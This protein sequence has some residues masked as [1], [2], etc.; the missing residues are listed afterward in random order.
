MCGGVGDLAFLLSHAGGQRWM[1][2]GATGCR[3]G[4]TRTVLTTSCCVPGRSRAAPSQRLTLNS[5]ACVSLRA[6]DVIN[7]LYACHVESASSANS[8]SLLHERRFDHDTWHKGSE[9]IVGM[10]S[11]GSPFV[12]FSYSSSVYK[13]PVQNILSHCMRMYVRCMGLQRM[14]GRPSS[15][16]SFIEILRQPDAIP[17]VDC[18]T[19]ARQP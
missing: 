3:R 6:C 10:C 13:Q 11:F 8:S 9:A 16:C 1:P 5:C 15:A 7:W 2:R 17:A 14:P 19:L 18:I 4:T 12:R